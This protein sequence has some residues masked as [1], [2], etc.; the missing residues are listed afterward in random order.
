MIRK[1]ILTDLDLVNGLKS[2]DEESKRILTK[3]YYPILYQYISTNFGRSLDKHTISDIVTDTILRAIEKID[4]FSLKAPLKSWLL[5]I[6]TRTFYNH[7]KKANLKKHSILSN[8]DEL[9]DSPYTDDKFSGSESKDFMNK[10]RKTLSPL[11]CSYLDLFLKEYTHKEIAELLDTTE[12]MSRWHKNN[13]MKKISDWV[14]KGEPSIK[15][16]DRGPKTKNKSESVKIEK[17]LEY[18]KEKKED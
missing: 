10:F 5:V 17:F 6:A 15:T 2:A 4:K 18:K 13:I 11:E 12:T 8:A 7:Y 1:E 9:T 3:V 16:K 14:K